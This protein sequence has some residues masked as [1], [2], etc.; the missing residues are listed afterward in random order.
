M[1]YQKGNYW[2]IRGNYMPFRTKEEAEAYEQKALAALRG[3][4]IEE[5][6]KPPMK[7]QIVEPIE[8]TP[9]ENMIGKTVCKLCDL[10]PCECF[11]FTKKTEP[12]R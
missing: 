10:E 3:E 1:I 4:V 9:Y 12:G 6:V 5:Y 11:I 7:E 8:N 2:K